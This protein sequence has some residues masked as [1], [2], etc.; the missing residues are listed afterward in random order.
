MQFL[1]ALL[2]TTWSRLRHR[3]HAVLIRAPLRVEKLIRSQNT[4]SS[5]VCQASG[6]APGALQFRL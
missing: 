4:H 3:L 5:T 2:M 1:I 6:G